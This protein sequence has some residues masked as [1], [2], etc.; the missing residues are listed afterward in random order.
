MYKS[1]ERRIWWASNSDPSI[2]LVPGD[3]G[4]QHS[5]SAGALSEAA[6]PQGTLHLRDF[7][8]KCQQTWNRT[9]KS[10]VFFKFAAN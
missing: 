9:E 1:M 5:S 6:K 3:F 10:T 2:T 4:P 7:D 8:Y